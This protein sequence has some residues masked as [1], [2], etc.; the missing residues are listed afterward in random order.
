MFVDY[1][2]YDARIRE[3]QSLYR[4]QIGHKNGNGVWDTNPYHSPI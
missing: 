3:L 1:P 4:R 2:V